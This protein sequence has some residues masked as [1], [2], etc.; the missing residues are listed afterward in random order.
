[1]SKIL[2]ATR[3]GEGSD[4]NVEQAIALAR[5]QCDELI[6]LFVADASFLAQMAAPVVVDVERRLEDMGRFQ[7]AR[8]RKQATARG[9]ETQTMVRRGRFRS[10][11]V[12]AAQELD[13]SLIVLGQPR[14]QTSVFEHETLKA[15]AAS[16][17]AETGIEVRIL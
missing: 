10:E 13:V 8:I 9:C 14:G 12:A 15:F 11:L 6:F 5:D 17:Q 16:L 4:K 7:L 1:M 2:C 3:G